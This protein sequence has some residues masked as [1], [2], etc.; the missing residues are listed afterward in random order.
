L[1]RH[2]CGRMYRLAVIH[3][4]TG[5]MTDSIVPTDHTEYD[6]LTDGLNV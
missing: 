5:R 2:F 1:F 4:L 6:W 3:F